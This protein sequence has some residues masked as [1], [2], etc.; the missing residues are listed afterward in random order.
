[1]LFVC[2]MLTMAVTGL[3]ISAVGGVAPEINVP[4]AL[5]VFYLVITSLTTVRPAAGS[6]W[7]D[8]A[9]MLMALAIGLSCFGLGFRVIVNGGREAGL[10]YPLFMF[11][12]VSLLASAGDRRMMR[13]GGV[14]GGPRLVRHLWGM[15]FALF[16]AS[17]AFYLGADRLPDMLRSPVFRAMGVLSPI[18]AM[19]YWIWRLRGRRSR[20]GVVRVSEPEAA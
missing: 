13:S 2:V 3:L 17:I 14:R 20:R 18:V 16:V 1:M 11:G 12:L 8:G 7:L 9:A 4:S 10:A 6:R 15:C 5:L 19:S